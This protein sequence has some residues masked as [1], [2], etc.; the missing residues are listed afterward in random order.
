VCL[1]LDCNY[2]GCWVDDAIKYIQE[3]NT[4]PFELMIVTYADNKSTVEW[5]A[6]R[7]FSKEGVNYTDV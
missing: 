2:A 6:G 5:K 3:G 7:Q 1:N 4:I